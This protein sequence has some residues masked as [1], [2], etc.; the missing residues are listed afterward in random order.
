MKVSDSCIPPD[1]SD[2]DLTWH[3]V[4]IP[5]TVLLLDCNEMPYLA[6]L[7]HHDV[8]LFRTYREVLPAMR[9]ITNTVFKVFVKGGQRELSPLI[10]GM[11]FFVIVI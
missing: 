3:P 4:F 2:L 1:H 9:H 8:K 11:I 5:V 7:P 6:I 10:R